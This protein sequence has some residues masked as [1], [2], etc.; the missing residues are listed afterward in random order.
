[1]GAELTE[2]AEEQS[3]QPFEM[4]SVVL[5]SSAEK[6]NERRNRG[7]LFSYLQALASTSLIFY[8]SFTT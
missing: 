6:I 5:Q 4:P 7:L 3:L 8:L 2:A 1:M